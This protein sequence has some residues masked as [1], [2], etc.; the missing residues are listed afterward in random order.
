MGSF[1][2]CHVSPKKFPKLFHRSNQEAEF[3]KTRV[4]SKYQSQLIYVNL[5]I[6]GREPDFV[7]ASDINNP[8]TWIKVI[9]F[10][11]NYKRSDKNG[12]YFRRRTKELRIAGVSCQVEFWENLKQV[13]PS[14]VVERVKTP[15]EIKVF[16]K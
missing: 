2:P 3:C 5:L 15:F 4:Y 14:F 7:I 13:T 9:E 8:E 11:P 10:H 1:V 6:N 12:K 16:V